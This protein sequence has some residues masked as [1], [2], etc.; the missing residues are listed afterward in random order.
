MAPI[1]NMAR[2][3]WPV[4]KPLCLTGIYKSEARELDHRHAA[5]A[6]FHIVLP[7][8]CRPAAE[9]GGPDMEQVGARWCDC[10]AGSR[11]GSSF[12]SIEGR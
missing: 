7:D 1:F 6:G 11:V 10:K 3:F 9:F 8:A 2:S 4:A 5:F 12:S